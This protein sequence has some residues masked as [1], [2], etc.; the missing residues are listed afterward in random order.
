MIGKITGRLEYVDGDRV[1]VDVHGVGILV[2]CSERTLAAL[3]GRGAV[4]ALYTELV[5]REDLLQ[6]IGFQTRMEREWHRLL[7]HVQG[8]GAKAALAIVG[9]LGHDGLMRAVML[10]DV[11]AIRAA[12]GIGPK[13]AQR[14]VVELKDRLPDI[15]AMGSEGVEP[16]LA[17][18]DHPPRQEAKDETVEPAVDEEVR[19]SGASLAAARKDALSALL[20][21]GYGQGEAAGA[22]AAATGDDVEPDAAAVIRAALR[23]LAPRG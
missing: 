19:D 9:T 5:V 1:L 4:I 13:L 14:V 15:M 6:L 12:P 21:L 10:E 11:A 2:T 16:A 7:T 22:I 18:Q 3:P 23:L 8:V 20:N 17:G